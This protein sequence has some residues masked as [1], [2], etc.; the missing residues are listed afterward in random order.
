ML[1]SYERFLRKKKL[2][3]RKKNFEKIFTICFFF[4]SFFFFFFEFFFFLLQ[5]FSAS[6]FT[7]IKFFFGYILSIF[8]TIPLWGAS[9]ASSGVCGRAKRAVGGVGERSEPPAGGLA[10]GAEGSVNSE[11]NEN[12]K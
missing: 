3:N 12:P 8:F 9:A 10:V 7:F 6:D 2:E 5:K 11:L 1:S 4:S